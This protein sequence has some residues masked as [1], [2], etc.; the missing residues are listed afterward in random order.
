MLFISCSPPRIHVTSE[1]KGKAGGLPGSLRSTDNSPFSLS[2]TSPM[3][4]S[5]GGSVGRFFKSRMHSRI[6]LLP[7]TLLTICNSDYRA[8]K[9]EYLIILTRVY[10]C[11]LRYTRKVKLARDERSMAVLHDMITLSNSAV[12]VTMVRLVLS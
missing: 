6:R 4:D 1:G 8:V 3:S 12:S 9:H 10:T 2:I 11:N 7:I 5:L